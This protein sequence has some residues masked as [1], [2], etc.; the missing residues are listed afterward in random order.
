MVRRDK[1]EKGIEKIKSVTGKGK[2]DS[3]RKNSKRKEK[4]ERFM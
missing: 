4:I 1:K 2:I 3:I